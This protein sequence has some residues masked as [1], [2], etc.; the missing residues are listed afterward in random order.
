MGFLPAPTPLQSDPLH[1]LLRLPVGGK[2]GQ[3]NAQ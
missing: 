2:A 3:D 1:L